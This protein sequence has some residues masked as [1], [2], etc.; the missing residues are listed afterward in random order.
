MIKTVIGPICFGEIHRI[1]I[2]VSLSCHRIEGHWECEKHVVM[3]GCLCKVLLREASATLWQNGETEIREVIKY[4]FKKGILSKEIHEDFVYLLGRR[5][6][7][8]AQ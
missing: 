5:L 6:L 1:K 4:F 3:L 2:V 7:L 8:I